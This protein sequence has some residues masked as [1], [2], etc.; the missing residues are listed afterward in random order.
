MWRVMTKT[1]FREFCRLSVLI[2]ANDSVVIR[3]VFI[4]KLIRSPI[5]SRLPF[6]KSICI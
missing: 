6:V 1:H 3:I 2:F 5:D 4:L